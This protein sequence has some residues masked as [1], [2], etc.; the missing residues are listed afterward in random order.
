M[1]LGHIIPT[2]VRIPSRDQDASGGRN[3]KELE[4]M[5]LNCVS[6]ELEYDFP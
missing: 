6:L 3:H 5:N 2:Y 1:W 4:K